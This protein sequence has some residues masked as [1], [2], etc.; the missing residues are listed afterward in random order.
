M[1]PLR[2]TASR[3]D[4][5]GMGYTDPRDHG[6]ANVEQALRSL[7]ANQRVLQ[8]ESGA[9]QTGTA[10]QRLSRPLQVRLARGQW[11]SLAEVPQVRFSV[12]G[13]GQ[14]ATSQDGEL[15]TEPVSVGP[16]P[17]ED[18]V[19]E[20]WWELGPSGT[21]EVQAQVE[22]TGNPNLTVA[23]VVLQA[24]LLEAEEIRYQSAPETPAITVKAALDQLLVQVPVGTIVEYA[25]QDDEL[26][27]EPQGFLLCDG[28]PV[29]TTTYAALFAVIGHAFRD[30]DEPGMFNL[31]ALSTAQPHLYKLI[32]F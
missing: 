7:Y 10:G 28:R 13:G 12:G 4:A 14:L 11:S 6:V 15:T 9:G 17:G 27:L 22:F 18:G 31:P 2:F 24:H 16:I 8:V 20:C 32:K 3:R 25:S 21:Q 26:R 29:S 23:P 5:A 19:Y 1:T 30:G